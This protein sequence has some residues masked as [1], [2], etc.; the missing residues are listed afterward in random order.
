[1]PT[2]LAVA[3]LAAAGGIFIGINALAY[4]AGHKRGLAEAMEQESEADEE[5]NEEALKV[6]LLDHLANKSYVKLAPSTVAGVGVFAVVDIPAAANPF[7]M[8]NAH[9]RGPER[10]VELEF[11]ELLRSCPSAVVDHVLN[12]H[13]A[14]DDGEGLESRYEVNATGM[15]SM[16]ASWYLNHSERANVIALP[17]EDDCGFTTYRTSRD[18]GAG[19][20]LLVDYRMGLPSLYAKMERERDRGDEAELQAKAQE[21]REAR[22][23]QQ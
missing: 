6:E 8:P 11:V 22:A 3:K 20:E 21:L 13:D 16:D 14:S 19:E 15:G 18:V 10:S 9:L 5:L 12:F 1:M 2:A 4:R 17:A 7:C 23:R